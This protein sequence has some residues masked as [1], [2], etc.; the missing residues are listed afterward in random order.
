MLQRFSFVRFGACLTLQVAEQVFE[1]MTL[2]ILT[3]NR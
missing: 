2:E 1:G 3:L